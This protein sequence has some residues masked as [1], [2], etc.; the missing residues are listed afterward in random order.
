MTGNTKGEQ[1]AQPAWDVATLFPAQGHWSD[2]EY[3]ALAAP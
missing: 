3:L 2:V 1:V